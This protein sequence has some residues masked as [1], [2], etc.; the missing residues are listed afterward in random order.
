[1]FKLTISQIKTIQGLLLLIIFVQSISLGWVIIIVLSLFSWMNEKVNIMYYCIL[2]Y[3]DNLIFVMFYIIISCIIV[4]L[5][6]FESVF[7]WCFLSQ[8]FEAVKELHK[9]RFSISINRTTLHLLFVGHQVRKNTWQC[10]STIKVKLHSSIIVPT[11]NQ[12]V[13]TFSTSQHTYRRSITK[14][15]CFLV[16]FW[17]SKIRVCIPSTSKNTT[18]F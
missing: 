9:F 11:K 16:I 4:F 15:F 3:D 10:L 13:I 17:W 8:F 14:V 2:N 1:M 7:S 12:F 18:C 6:N 5:I